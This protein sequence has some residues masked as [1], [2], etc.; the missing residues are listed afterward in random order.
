MQKTTNNKAILILVTI[1]LFLLII[2]IF[3]IFFIS[4]M[5]NLSNSVTENLYKEKINGDLHS[6]YKIIYDEYGAITI[7]SDSLFNAR[8]VPINNDYRLVDHLKEELNLDVSIYIKNG[9]E[10]KRILTTVHDVETGTRIID[11]SLGVSSSAYHLLMNGKIY[12]GKNEVKGNDY[13]SGYLP[14]Y[15]FGN[16][17]IGLLSVGISVEQAR[18]LSNYLFGNTITIM[19]FVIVS[20]FLAYSFLSYCMIIYILRPFNNN[21]PIE[22]DELSTLLS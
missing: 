19:L 8:G 13:I 2:T 3:V 1:F 12:I 14:I 10:F 6:I 17:I 21:E 4:Q 18:L 22:K 7:R 11:T 15:T 16:E 9:L 5:N 20:C